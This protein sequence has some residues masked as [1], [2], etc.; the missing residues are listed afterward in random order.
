MLT[1]P[2]LKLI[3]SRTQVR[4][5]GQVKAN[6]FHVVEFHGNFSLILLKVAKSGETKVT[7]QKQPS[8]NLPL[9]K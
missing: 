9:T 5:A 3:T 2:A 7:A 4:L 8:N 6:L 1:F